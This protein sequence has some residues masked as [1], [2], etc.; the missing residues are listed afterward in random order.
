[1]NVKFDATALYTKL[2]AGTKRAQQALDASI[3]KYGNLYCPQDTGNL[4]K[5]AINNTKIGSGKV[6]WNTPYAKFQY[7]NWRGIRG[8]NRNP[9]ATSKWVETALVNHIND[10]KAA[11]IAAYSKN[12]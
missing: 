6:V 3:V 4:Q 1:M 8:H 11:V 7:Y 2:E 12:N 5:S 10:I 9:K